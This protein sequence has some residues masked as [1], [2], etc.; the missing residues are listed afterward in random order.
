M[1]A[2]RAALI[3]HGCRRAWLLDTEY[4]PVLAGLQIPIVFAPWTSSL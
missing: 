4:K 1:Q 3:A 2:V